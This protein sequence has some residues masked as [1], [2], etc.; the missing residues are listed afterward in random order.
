MKILFVSL[1]NAKDVHSW[2]G[3]TYNISNSLSQIDDVELLYIDDLLNKN[4]DINYYFR[5]IKKLLYK[6]FN[7]HY[8]TKLSERFLKKIAKYVLNTMPN[9]IDCILS[10]SSLVFAYM[11]T[12]IPKVFYTD[13]SYG[14]MQDYYRRKENTAKETLKL[15]DKIEKLALLNCTKAIY[16]SDWAA[17]QTCNYYKISSEKVKV[18]PFGANFE[19]E[20]D[21][22]GILN[23]IRQKDNDTC[24]L[25]FIGVEWERKGGDIL[26]E[27]YKSLKAFG[28]KVKLHIVGIV[29]M[30]FPFEENDIINY[31]YISKKTIEG[32]QKLTDIFKE[33]HFLLLPSK[34]EAY[35]LVLCEANSFGLPSIAFK[36]GGVST[37][38]R[39][40][41]NGKTFNL[42]TSPITI[43]AYIR[44]IFTNKLIYENMS[45]SSYDEYI[46]R[47]NWKV[48]AISLFNE[49]KKNE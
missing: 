5:Q 49:L 33:S 34:A 9:N 24:N 7:I 30:R 26:I 10:D 31:G 15:G 43:G 19:S 36:T 17:K 14:I 46:A 23:L 8:D 48:S 25:L 39:D 11:S 1:S 32:K 38:V 42:Q 21:R 4:K 16:S 44:D 40:D 12:E 47:L 22:A 29:N 41:I 27:V 20:F 45:M 37:I 13:S 2:S 35:G 28:I 6:V 18:I 3:L